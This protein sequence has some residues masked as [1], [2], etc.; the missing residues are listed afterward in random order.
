MSFQKYC[1]L[2]L[3]NLNIIE[4]DSPNFIVYDGVLYSSDFQTVYRVPANFTG[5][6]EH[7]T[8]FVAECAVFSGC[9]FSEYK[10]EARLE[11]LGNSM[12]RNCRNLRSIDL[13]NTIAT[14]CPTEIFNNCNIENLILPD[15]LIYIA[16][17]LNVFGSITK[18]VIP[19]SVRVIAKDV[20]YIASI[21]SIE[22][23]GVYQLDCTAVG[24]PN[25]LVSS[26]Y[27]YNSFFGFTSF[28]NTLTECLPART[29]IMTPSRTPICYK[30]VSCF[31][32]QNFIKVTKLLSPIRF[33]PY[34]KYSLHM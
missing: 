29:P 4:S 31:N 20:L 12:F 6:L 3:E 32:I 17:Y 33:A 21:Q 9:T 1:L 7:T 14:I 8:K 19:A 16:N 13:S 28:S 10:V 27:N 18:L 24:T 23:C 15:T 34:L 5:Q 22:Y 11:T 2:D 26:H 25:L 30:S